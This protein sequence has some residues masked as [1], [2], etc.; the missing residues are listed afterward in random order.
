MYKNVAP[1]PYSAYASRIVGVEQVEARFRGVVGCSPGEAAHPDYFEFKC[2]D[3]RATSADA[4]L[5]ASALLFELDSK[6]GLIDQAG[7]EYGSD[8]ERVY[9]TLTSRGETTPAY[10]SKSALL[11]LDGA[12]DRGLLEIFARYRNQI[13]EAALAFHRAN[14]LC[15]VIVLGSGNF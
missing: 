1:L 4:R 10:V 8:G 3:L 5:D 15:T 13:A 2:A 11:T 14:P 12:S 7:W 6:N 9:F